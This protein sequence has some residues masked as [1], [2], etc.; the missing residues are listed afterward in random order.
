MSNEGG[1]LRVRVKMPEPYVSE[2]CCEETW[3]EEA[4]RL[5]IHE[6]FWGL[7]ES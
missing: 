6:F 7:Q 3:L 1:Y 4:I 2:V 5:T